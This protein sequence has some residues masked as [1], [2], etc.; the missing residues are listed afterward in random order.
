[1]TSV[2]SKKKLNQWIHR[3]REPTYSSQGKGW[4]K[5]QLGSLVGTCTQRCI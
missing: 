2:E 5:G 4:G 3:L 1:M